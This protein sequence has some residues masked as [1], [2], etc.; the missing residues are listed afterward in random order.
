MHGQG[1]SKG[2]CY[3]KVHVLED[4]P[5][6][7][8][9]EYASAQAEEKKFRD[10]L[11]DVL[12]ETE[13]MKERALCTVG[14]EA[15][16]ILDAHCS[17]LKDEGMLDPISESI[18]DGTNAAQSVENAMNTF[19]EMFEGMENEYMA[20][21]ALDLK[22]I[23]DR[24]IRRILH[25]KKDDLSNLSEM[26]ILAG[27]DIAPSITAGMDTEH[28]AGMLME[29][30]G[31]T[32]HT[33]ILARTLDVPA[34]VGASGLM[35]EIKTGDMIAFDGETGEIMINPTSEE[36]KQFQESMKKQK[37]EKEKLKLFSMR[38]AETKDHQQ[39][40]VCGNIGGTDDLKKVMEYGAD[41]VG[42][43][44]SEFLFLVSASLPTE[45]QQLA[46]YKTVLEEIKDKPVIVRTLDIGG[47]KEVK[48]LG[49][50]KEENP[51][52]GL[53]AIR[54]CQA[55][56]EVFHTQLRALLRASVYGN[57]QIMFPMISSLQE[58][59][60][61]K[62]Q[63]EYCKKQLEEE[64]IPYKQN[65]KVGIMIEIP[66]TAVMARQ[67][68]AE[69]DFFSIGTNDLTQYT[70]AVDR[71]NDD[72]AGLYSYFH[73]AVLRMIEM[74]IEGAHA[75]GIPCGMCGEAAGN[76]YML[77]ILIGLGLDEYS[78]TASS[79]LELKQA[80]SRID[81]AECKEL[82]ARVMRLG[83]W[84]EV[85]TELEKFVAERN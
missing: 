60:W 45:E 21:R 65:I 56:P 73:P 59:R 12:S 5:I 16:E 85:R 63:L 46:A 71:G 40:N 29:L 42:L 75:Q 79:I 77:P 13:E 18:Q 39:L 58:L 61:A 36:V 33:A 37:E 43:F 80:A 15:A 20:Q 81:T 68:A 26:M 78:M 44:R 69:C 70:L 32:S 83:T 30:G 14:K 2:L 52:L 62:E 66:A 41:G 38:R 23:K 27:E 1:V 57:L 53:R 11:A 8:P 49:L 74:A 4:K 17:L 19:I 64:Q 47:D 28:L 24:L 54:L 9:T 22:D 6:Q 48:A 72:V 76:A 25:I 55:K 82:A 51:F 35:N 34:V 31:V 7:F 84:D 67:F 50:K 10:A 3:A